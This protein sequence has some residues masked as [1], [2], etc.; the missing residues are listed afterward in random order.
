M[1]D[2]F[3]TRPK[4]TRSRLVPPN[5]KRIY[6]QKTPHPPLHHR[7]RPLRLPILPTKHQTTHRPTPTITIKSDPDTLDQAHIQ[8][9]SA[10]AT[11]DKYYHAIET[12]DLRKARHSLDH[13]V[14]LS[15][16]LIYFLGEELKFV[17]R[18]K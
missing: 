16:E 10:V 3:F 12:Q 9:G 13:A 14:Y 7:R 1:E 18:K 17:P 15:H 2:Y 6:Q 11:L 8:L 4:Q 5:Q